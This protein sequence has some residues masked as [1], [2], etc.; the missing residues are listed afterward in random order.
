MPSCVGEASA[1]YF[2]T[3][4]RFSPLRKD[5]TDKPLLDRII[6]LRPPL[7]GLC[8]LRLISLSPKKLIGTGIFEEKLVKK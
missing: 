6:T 1:K 3:T 4:P 5:I 8:V 7:I 2:A